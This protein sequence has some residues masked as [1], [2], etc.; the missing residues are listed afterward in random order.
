MNLNFDWNYISSGSP[1]VRISSFGISFNS[2]A[3]SLLG[4][5]DKVILGFDPDKLAIGIKKYAG[6]ENV[7]T[8]EFYDRM[9]NGWIRIGCKDFVKYLGVLAEIDFK[10]SVRY[11]PTYDSETG[12]LYIFVKEDRI[13]KEGDVF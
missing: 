7:K 12:V 10:N 2:F 3:I 9:K 5:P 13:K 4:N 1:Y 6:E 11:I 8:Y